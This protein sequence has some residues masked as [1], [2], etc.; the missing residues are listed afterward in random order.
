MTHFLHS[1]LAASGNEPLF[2]VGLAKLEK[3]AGDSGV[4][5]RLIADILEKAHIVM[6]HLG[7]DTKNTTAVE[8][9]QALMASVKDNS[10]ESI[11]LD[12]DYVLLPVHGKIIS[13]NL[14]DVINN[15]HHELDFER[16]ISSHG[17]RSLRGEMIGR[18]LNHGR[19]DEAVTN[20]IAASMGLLAERDTW[21]DTWYDKYK[22]YRKQIIINSEELSR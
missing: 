11:L 21:F 3:A 7:L 20:E 5:T 1:V 6:R 12:S 22:H 19:T 17:K 4:D 9:Y 2:N 18:Y 8:L 13:L 10:C 15:A 14:I 16:Q